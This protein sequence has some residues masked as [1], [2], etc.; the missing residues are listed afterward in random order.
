MTFK[1]PKTLI[2][3]F[4]GDSSDITKEFKSQ[5]L[6]NY[7]TNFSWNT[8]LFF[9]KKITFHD[10]DWVRA[11]LDNFLLLISLYTPLFNLQESQ[12]NILTAQI[13]FNRWNEFLLCIK[14]CLKGHPV[15]FGVRNRRVMWKWTS[16][17]VDVLLF[18]GRYRFRFLLHVLN[19]F[20]LRFATLALFRNFSGLV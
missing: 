16:N 6:E 14:G 9:Q 13:L 15:H 3:F 17:F 19:S 1:L 20:S 12:W 5:R 2:L 8:N 4:L 11:L 7:S 10:N 18:G